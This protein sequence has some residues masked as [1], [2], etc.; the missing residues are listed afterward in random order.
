MLKLFLGN[1]KAQRAKVNWLCCALVFCVGNTFSQTTIVQNGASYTFMREGKPYYVRGVGGEVNLDLALAIGANSIRTWGV[2]NAQKVL[3]EAQKKGLTVMLGFWLQQERGGFDYNDKDKV[4]KQFNYYK[5]M[6]DK[7]KNHPALLMWGIGNELNLNYTNTIVWNAVQDLAKYAHQVDPNHPT[8]TVTAGLDSM[9]VQLIKKQAPDIDV[10]CINTYGDIADV[11]K[12]M[13]QYGWTGPYMITEW[14]P[15]GHWESP[16]TSWNV[17]IEQT[18]TEKKQVY[19][20]RYKNYIEPY[21]NKCLG[22]YAFFWGSKQEYTETWYGLFSKDNLPTEPIDALEIIFRNQNPQI[23]SPTITEIT[24]QNQTSKDNITL[25]AEDKFTASVQSK[26]A[27]NMTDL[28]EDSKNKITYEWKILAESTDKKSGGDAE[29]EA[30]E[31]SGLIKHP[32]HASIQFRAPHAAG[33]YRLFVRLKYN[34]KLAYANIPFKV[35]AR[36]ETDKQARFIELKR[37]SMESFN[38]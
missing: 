11:P 17:S 32:N 26:I 13:E 9:E 33:E 25:K 27:I 3:D 28:I 6:I 36:N 22:S 31:I 16:T 7:Y 34:N 5:S 29:L 4:L 19:Y 20:D 15:D 24:L 38:H 37:V 35:I 18:S 10:Y 14:G 2:E 12:Y 30:S 8:S 21:K 1:I 23:P